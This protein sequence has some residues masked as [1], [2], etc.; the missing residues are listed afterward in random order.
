MIPFLWQV[1]HYEL[2]TAKDRPQRDPTSWQFGIVR[3]DGSFEV[4]SEMS[5][6]D[7]PY[8]RES[9][10]EQTSPCPSC[11]AITDAVQP[12]LSFRC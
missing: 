6:V 2:W 1:T 11:S 3:P 8:K 5:E 7:P 4:L 12:A 9:R 10:Y